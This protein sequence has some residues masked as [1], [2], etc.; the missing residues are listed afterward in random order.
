MPPKRRS[1]RKV[2]DTPKKKQATKKAA[3]DA[4][5]DV[6]EEKVEEETTPTSTVASKSIPNSSAVTPRALLFSDDEEDLEEGSNDDVKQF[7]LRHLE[8]SETTP[9]PGRMWY[10]CCGRDYTIS[11]DLNLVVDI[12]TTWFVLADAEDSDIDPDGI[13]VSCA[14]NF[15]EGMAIITQRGADN[16]VSTVARARDGISRLPSPA[17]GASTK[18]K[19][20]TD[21]S[22]RTVVPTFSSKFVCSPP[23]IA[24]S[25]RIA[26]ATV[27]SGGFGNPSLLKQVSPTSTTSRVTTA[28][29]TMNSPKLVPKKSSS[30][31][32]AV[33]PPNPYKKIGGQTIKTEKRFDLRAST[34]DV[35]MVQ[36]LVDQQ[37][38]MKQE[39]ADG[40]PNHF[41]LV[42]GT[43]AYV[44]DAAHIGATGI[45]DLVSPGMKQYWSYK[46]SAVPVAFVA[47]CYSDE[48]L[49]H[50][51]PV[52]S[53]MHTVIVRR[54]P[55]GK[56][57]P[58][59][60]SANQQ[61]RTYNVEAIAFYVDL[62][63]LIE[64]GEERD[65][66][67]AASM[68][69]AEIVGD[70]HQVFISKLFRDAFEKSMESN[71]RVERFAKNTLSKDNNLGEILHAIFQW[72]TVSCL[73]FRCPALFSLAPID[74]NLTFVSFL[75]R[76]AVFDH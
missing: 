62:A 44:K 16:M 17:A 57:M 37:A 15:T 39:A 30:A 66:Q 48:Q 18:V 54:H 5:K 60:T 61:G 7:V 23:S 53:T 65:L 10:V 64:Q 13:Y 31:S 72:M 73:S 26:P 24:P 67:S 36:E 38:K 70:L 63:P 75:S 6:A 52:A 32:T 46:P 4:A 55:H 59:K 35:S 42:A 47:A 69:L 51:R 68:K 14:A 1:N 3:K 22:P 29:A 27:S 20:V 41:F 11:D 76:G 43:G 12:A 58:K 34:V 19:L 40:G 45:I 33:I 50:L 28:K 8:T 9:Q 25:M 2:T 74:P 49:A 71:P 21:E 56:N